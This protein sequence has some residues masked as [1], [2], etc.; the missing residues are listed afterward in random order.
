MLKLIKN[1]ILYFTLLYAIVG[2]IV[3]PLVLKPKVI[4]AASKE[5]NAKLSI[6]SIY[7]NPFAFYLKISGLKLS[8]LENKELIYLESIHL[9]VEPYSLIHSAIHIDSL[10]LNKP[11]ISLVLDKD[12]KINFNSIIKKSPEV[13]KESTQS[14]TEIPRIILDRIAIVN[15]SVLYDDYSHKSK[16]DFK[17][18]N[19]GFELKNIDTK[20]LT[21]SDATLRFYTQ[22]ADGGFIDFKSKIVGLEPLIVEGSLD[23]EASKLYTQ[24]RYIQDS[25]NIEVADGKL[26]LHTNYN[27]NLEKLENT[28]LSNFNF[29]LD[30][31]RIKPKGQYKD[32]LTLNSLSLNDATIKPLA[33][34]IHLKKIAL[35]SLYI[36]AKRDKKGN[37]DWLEYIKFTPEVQEIQKE[38]TEAKV[39]ENPKPWNLLVDEIALEKIKVNFDD[40]GIR[41][42]VTT[43]LDSLNIY[44]QNVTLDGTKPFNYQMN[45]LLNKKLKCNSSGE[46]AHKVLD[47]SSEIKCKDIDLVHYRPYIDSIARSELKVYDIKLRRLTAEFDAKLTAKE[48]DSKIV[49]NINDANFGLHKFSLNQRSTNKRLVDFSSFKVSGI[50][51]NSDTKEIGIKD[52][53]LKY[54]NIRTSRLKDSTLNI[55]DLVVPRTKKSKAKKKVK[56][57]KK[58]KAYRVRLKK[59]ALKGAKVSFE[60]KLLSPST[61]AKIDAIYLSAYNIDSKSYSWMR[62]NFS[63]RVNETGKIKSKGSLRHTPLKQKGNFELNRISLK[64]LTPYLQEKA[65]VTL[66]DGYLSLKTDTLYEVSKTKPDLSLDGSF[67]LQE[68]FINDSRDQSSLISFSDIDLKKFTLELSPNRLF[69]DEIDVNAFYVNAMVDKEKVM[70][71]ATLMKVS[72]DE[73]LSTQN[74]ETSLEDS[75]T[76]QSQPFPV[77]IMKI[78][79]ALGSAQFSDDSLPIP[80]KTNIHDLNG[81][82]Y[83]V[84][85][86]PNETSYINIAGEI[87]K[88]GSTKL[89]GSVNSSNPKAFTD[90]D[91][92]FRN[93]DLS[94]MSGYTSTFAG[95]NIEKGKLF[96]NLNYDI[97]DSEMLGENSIIVKD[98]ELGKEVGTE[99]GSSLPLGFVIALL[100]DS[101][102]VIDID[103]PIRGNIDEPDFKYG[104][105]VL[106]TF[107]NLILK[108]VTSPFRFLGSMMGMDGDELEYAEFEAGSMLILPSEREKLDNVAKLLIKRPKISLSV[109]G[110]YNKEV[111]KLALQKKK[112]ADVVVKLSDAKNE[113]ERESAMTIDLLEDIYKDARDDDKLDKLED[114]LEKKYKD[115]AYDREYQKALLKLCI[116]VQEVS[117][118]EMQKLAKKRSEILKTYLVDTKGIEIHR[119]QELEILTGEIG[120]N[121]L[122]QSK[123]KVIIK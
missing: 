68:F 79:V 28:T 69:V 71:F 42:K 99:D 92:N 84:S 117:E 20:D 45:M 76:T 40:N 110:R 94:S 44:A 116:N 95:H 114:A 46:V 6:D 74:S 54:L 25:L 15:G 41:P 101:D 77:K 7:F 52:T 10:V 113:Q 100:E 65:H 78:N 58:E 39:E 5:L 80:F 59:F 67:K 107:A 120:E 51:L 21:T 31:L 53:T 109:G 87:D 47:L 86:I 4:E 18:D 66:D 70:N 12:K 37:I 50:T 9:N 32:I 35:D 81:V 27:F 34:D 119:I 115:E 2:F 56:K 64:E 93:L 11:K 108:A 103:M 48:L 29:N 61:K 97:L 13:Q 91:F 118:M 90:L 75:N 104:A 38:E 49:L 30:K 17:I 60:D 123:L 96:L 62:Y 85:S 88:Y 105:L 82:I 102:G 8:S 23:Y 33:Q 89:K 14:K 22:L 57:G 83:A 122:V 72:E 63:A 3:L 1:I 43:T 73:N 36:Q 98:I 24:W 111:D 26:S 112:L 55:Q 106:K 19:L 16:F 121:N